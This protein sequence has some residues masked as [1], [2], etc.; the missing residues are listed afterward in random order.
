[1]EEKK[2]IIDYVELVMKIFGFAIIMLNIFCILF[3][4]DAKGFSSIFALGKEGI[5]ISTMLE[6]L[7]VAVWIT[8][9]RFLFFSDVVVKNKGIPFR[10]CGMIGSVLVIISIYIWSFQWFPI[11]DWLCW[12]MFFVSFGISFLVS[13][14]VTVIKERM[15]NR[16]MEEALDRL[17]KQAQQ[18]EK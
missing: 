1:M 6:F 11:G 15:E 4:E 13:L 3:G 14:G 8:L 5:R 18:K 10:T 12:F 2:T 17:K 9:T 7:S 16:R